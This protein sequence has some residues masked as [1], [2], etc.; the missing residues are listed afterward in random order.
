MK[1]LLRNQ[2]IASLHTMEEGIQYVAG[3]PEDAAAI[4][5]DCYAAVGTVAAVLE[6]NLSD[7]R[8]LVLEKKLQLVND[9][10]EE[11][12]ANLAG[13][14]GLNKLVKNIRYTLGRIEKDLMEDCEAKTE[15]VFLPYKASMWDSLESIWRAAVLDDTCE[16]SVVPVPYFERNPA[17]E[18]IL[19]YD[20][21]LF[22]AETQP[23]RYQDFDLP[24]IQPDIIY[25]HNIY[26]ENNTVTVLPK[27][28]HTAALKKNTRMLVYV[29]Y[30]VNAE[31]TNE[32]FVRL[33][34]LTNVDRVVAA[35]E[36]EAE[37]YRKY[38]PREKVWPLGSPKIDSVVRMEENPPAVPQQWQDK[39]KGKKVVLYN[40][41]VTAVLQNRNTYLAKLRET[42]ALFEKREDAVLLWRPHP[43]I[44]ATLQAMAPGLYEEYV[45]LEQEF[46]RKD[47]GIYDGSPDYHAAFYLA[48]AFYGD[49]GSLVPLFGLTGKP[50]LLQDPGMLDIEEDDGE[51]N[52]FALVDEDVVW[53]FSWNFN[54]LQKIDWRTG[55]VEYMGSAPGE[56]LG[57]EKLYGGPVN[58]GDWLVF[59]PIAAKTILGY[60]KKTEEFTNWDLPALDLG[61]GERYKFAHGIYAFGTVWLFGIFYEGI[62]KLDM[63]TGIATV[64]DGWVPELRN[65]KKGDTVQTKQCFEALRP[66]ICNGKIWAPIFG[67]STLLA[68]DIKSEKWEWVEVSEV[69]GGYAAI[70]VEGEN[71]WLLSRKSEQAIVRINDETGQQTHFGGNREYVEAGGPV[72][73]TGG[74]KAGSYLWGVTNQMKA[75]LRIDLKTGDSLYSAKEDAVRPIFWGERKELLLLSSVATGKV[76]TIET[77]TQE[78]VS[79]KKMRSLAARNKKKEQQDS[80]SKPGWVSPFR[81]AYRGYFKKE[82]REVATLNGLIE[83][84]PYSEK[85]MDKQNDILG[86]LFVHGDGT[87]GEAVFKSSLLEL[88][89]SV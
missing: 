32:D 85:M 82:N 67:N 14:A 88:G 61:E 34:G 66:V 49:G 78:T 54:G 70:A 8:Y 15:V 31:I 57:A 38:W 73:F 20:G 84:M 47:I 22:P 48:D 6:G 28:Y 63:E 87:T 5:A 74:G 83:E 4:L 77:E 55:C 68:I 62:V 13:G 1:K 11:L 39:A 29:P 35:T 26:D 79:T 24:T 72:A 21:P 42:I 45:Q 43:L 86:A 27:E 51:P 36:K 12:A 64:C 80:F 58:V 89:R 56:E 3:R 75:L 65:W 17:G 41:T 50:I 7:R 81:A 33:P 37:L 9:A 19:Q 2:I 46:I 18:I 44:K 69:S 60:N 52:S 59:P 76:N 16:V 30:F 25:V 10:M 23:I 40:S 53:Q 71:I